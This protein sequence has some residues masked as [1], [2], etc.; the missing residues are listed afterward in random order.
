MGKPLVV[1]GKH[2]RYI[3]VDNKETFDENFDAIEWGQKAITNSRRARI[4][5]V[6]GKKVVEDLDAPKAGAEI[7][8]STM[9]VTG[10]TI[11]VK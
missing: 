9:E 10:P 7:D 4:R 1:G 3:R 6:D 11:I 2:N 5:F 8:P